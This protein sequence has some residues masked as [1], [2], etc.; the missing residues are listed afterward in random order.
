[1]KPLLL[2]LLFIAPLCA[3]TIDVTTLG[4]KPDGT[5][6]AGP[7]IQKAFSI[8]K[9]HGG[10]EIYFPCG[11]NGSYYAIYSPLNFPSGT[12]I[13]GSH[14]YG[15]QIVYRGKN[16]APAAFSFLNTK[17]TTV[18]DLAMFVLSDATPP[19][20]IVLFGGNFG[21]GQNTLDHVTIGGYAATTMVYSISSENN[22]LRGVYFDLYGGGAQIGFYT[23]S[24]DDFGLC[25]TCQGT[26][27]LS[28]TMESPIF[29]LN[30][31]RQGGQFTAV[32]D[33]TQGGAGDH[34]YLNGYI[35]LGTNPA[36]TGFKFISGSTK[37]DGP[38]SMIV[39]RNFRIENGGYG[40]QF[41]KDYRNSIYNVDIENV[42]WD[43]S[44]AGAT[45]FMQG[46]SGLYLK[47]MHWV[48]NLGENRNPTATSSIDSL[49]YSQVEENYGVFNIRNTGG[50]THNYF[51]MTGAG[52]LNLPNGGS[53]NPNNTLVQIQ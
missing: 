12:T 48:K 44:V 40:V 32:V 19:G 4:A 30:P 1:M 45:G 34:Y 26:S 41:V 2:S 7:A 23:S 31:I 6:D 22:V 25:P 52:K 15:C 20:S 18:K 10:S 38:N 5:T 50:T 39:L 53:L 28:L 37:H 24:D 17:Y 9:A 16:S 13:R 29:A 14:F 42:T 11:A 8:A 51:L 21:S 35:G 27:N 46:D 49:Q 36:S 33:R 43:T 47:N 3:Q